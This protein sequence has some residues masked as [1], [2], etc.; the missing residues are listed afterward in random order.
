MILNFLGAK[1]VKEHFVIVVRV[2][3]FKFLVNLALKG[4]TLIIDG[5]ELH[6]LIVTLFFERFKLCGRLACLLLNVREELKKVLGVF[7]KH[8]LGADKTELAHLIEICQAFNFLVLLLKEHLDQEHLSLFLD[9]VPTVLPVLRAFNRHVKASVLCH[10]NLVCDIRVDGQRCRLNIGFTKFA[11]A[12]FPSWPILLPNFE[13]LVGLSLTLL[14]CA[15]LILESEDA[16]VTRVR[17]RI[18]VL[19]E[20]EEGLCTLTSSIATIGVLPCSGASIQTG[21]TLT[22]F[23]HLN[24]N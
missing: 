17:K 7:L 21:P 6:G 22:H 13:F 16:I 15:L 9:K 23:T 12:A 11:E 24:S 2:Q 5:S 18:R 19:F 10:I 20:A 1:I 14:P 8:L 3:I 4:C